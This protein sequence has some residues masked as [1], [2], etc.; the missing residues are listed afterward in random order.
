[1][2]VDRHLFSLR[3]LVKE[4]DPVPAIFGGAFVN[5]QTSVL[6]TS[7]VSVFG[8]AVLT[9]GFGAVC[10]QGYGLGYVCKKD[11]IDVCITCFTGD[12]DT[13]GAGFGGVKR[14]PTKAMKF[15]TS[16]VIFAENLSWALNALKDLHM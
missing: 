8:A 13:G 3:S 10:P 5:H 14:D 2:A 9:A 7:N 16:A 1:M 6:S 11:R 4:G 15:D 12:P